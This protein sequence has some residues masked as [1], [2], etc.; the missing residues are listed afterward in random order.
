MIRFRII[1]AGWTRRIDSLLRPIV[2]E[3]HLSF[4]GGLDIEAARKEGCVKT[5][6]EDGEVGTG[7]K[8]SRGYPGEPLVI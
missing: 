5:E 8:S 2:F 3:L 4:L 1:R 6:C 7:Y